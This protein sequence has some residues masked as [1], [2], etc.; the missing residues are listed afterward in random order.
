[1]GAGAR[2]NVIEEGFIDRGDGPDG[3][4]AP[5]DHPKALQKTPEAAVAQLLEFV[6]DSAVTAVDGTRVPIRARTFRLHSDTPAAAGIAQAVREA[7]E[8]EK[9]TVRPL[10]ELL[11]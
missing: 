8:R 2:A 1:M 5:R 6:Q 9:I 10:R 3:R 7:V 4:L 11:A